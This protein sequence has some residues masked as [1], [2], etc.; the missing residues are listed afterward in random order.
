VERP[1]RTIEIRRLELVA[2][3][4]AAI[5]LVCE[6]T[7]GTYVRVLGG[8]LARSLG[9]VG[10][11]TKLHRAWVEP[12][13][14]LPMWSLEAALEDA[15]N[16]RQGLLPSDAALGGLPEAWLT[17]EQVTVLRHG[18]SVRCGCRPEAQPG[19]R[20]RLY[21]PGGV[22]LGLAEVLADGRLQPRR[23]LHPDAT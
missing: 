20:A 18:Q 6:C 7:K 5:D 10:H 14:D 23:L 19:R 3:R 4:E 13:Q 12:F 9:T 11:L 2:I 21:A 1:A 15:N 16:N 22:F 17:A 8:D